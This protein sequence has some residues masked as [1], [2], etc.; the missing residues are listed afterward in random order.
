VVDHQ[1]NTTDVAIVVQTDLVTGKYYR[2]FE[3]DRDRR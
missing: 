2:H 3:R 1:F